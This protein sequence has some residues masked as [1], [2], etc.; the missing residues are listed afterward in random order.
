MAAWR[1]YKLKERGKEKIASKTEQNV[2]KS[3]LLGD[4]LAPPTVSMFAGGKWIS[5]LWVGGNVRN[6]KFIPLTFKFVN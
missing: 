5:K 2:L 3:H 6:A 4:K 1:Y